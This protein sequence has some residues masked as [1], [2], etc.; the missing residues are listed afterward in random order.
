M[1]RNM[2]FRTAE[3]IANK[4]AGHGGRITAIERG[5]RKSLGSF[6]GCCTD[7]VTLA[8]SH[9]HN[10]FGLVLEMNSKQSRTVLFVTLKLYVK[11][12]R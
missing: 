2:P 8:G 4:A 11:W 12:D 10:K 3:A 7:S 9:H 1:V 5:S 6:W